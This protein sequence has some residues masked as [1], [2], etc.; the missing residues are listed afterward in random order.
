MLKTTVGNESTVLLK[1]CGCGMLECQGRLPG[2]LTLKESVVFE[3]G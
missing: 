3:Q 1:M 2:Y